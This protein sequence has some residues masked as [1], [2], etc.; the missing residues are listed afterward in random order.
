M[1]SAKYQALPNDDYDEELSP[2]HNR[3]LP[4]HYQLAQ[5]PRFNPPTPPW[6]KRALI[7]LFIIAMFWLYFS[8]QQGAGSKVIHAQRFVC[9]YRFFFF[10]SLRILIRFRWWW[11]GALIFF[12]FTFQRY[13][14]QYKFRP[15]AS[16][17]IYEKLKGGQ[18]RVRGAA[19][20]FRNL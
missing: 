17:V 18:T 13:S 5:D 11:C 8:M 7:I 12:S 15:A 14:K 6:W 3:H 9:I 16:P 20:S 2:V 10:I 1:S 4:E 19:P